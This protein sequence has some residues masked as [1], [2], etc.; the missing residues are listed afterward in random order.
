MSQLPPHI[1]LY[2]YADDTAFLTTGNT[3]HAINTTLQPAVNAFTHWCTKWKL[4]IN[5]QKTQALIVLPPRCRSRV[6]RNPNLFHIT[7]NEIPV[8]HHPQATYLGVI[9]DSKFTWKPHMHKIRTQAA[10]RLNLLKRLVGTSWGL[11]TPTVIKTY[12]VF[13]RPALTYGHTKDRCTK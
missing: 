5:A 8:R 11:H 1:S 10:Q 3:I 12:K 2:Q 4:T 9:F 13:I 6:R 7:V